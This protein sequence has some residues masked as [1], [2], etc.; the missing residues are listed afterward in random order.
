MANSVAE[1]KRAEATK[2]GA[3][4]AVAAGATVAV[5][6]VT[7]SPVL[8]VGGAVGTA[9]LGYRWIKYRIKEGIRF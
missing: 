8:I 4:T 6:V 7:A 5:A 9:V 2:K 3:V 1:A